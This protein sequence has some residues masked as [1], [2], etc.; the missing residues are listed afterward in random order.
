MIS[1]VHI[2]ESLADKQS[3]MP[4]ARDFRNTSEKNNKQNALL[5]LSFA[6]IKNIIHSIIRIGGDC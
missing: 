5:N 4:L 2:R 3:G 1:A 6:V